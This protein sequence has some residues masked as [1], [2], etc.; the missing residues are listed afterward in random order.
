MAL[1]LH[2]AVR[3]AIPGINPDVQALYL[4][5]RGFAL[6]ATTGVSTPVYA[7]PY[8]VTVQV[9]PP[10]GR[11]LQ[12]INMLNLQGVVRTIYMYGN[13]QAINRV[14]AGGADL[15]MMP[16][17]QPHVTVD[18]RGGTV[19]DNLTNPILGAFPVDNWIVSAVDE[20]Y[21][22]E[23]LGW[24][25]LYVTLQTDGP[26]IVFDSNRLPVLDSNGSLVTSQ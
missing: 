4:A 26:Y 18:N 2:N 16:Q 17:W 5:S 25:K 23:G 10:S 3:S 11:D 24:T 9:Q 20:W 21:D 7:P 14:R 6:S 12:H 22:I 15:I 13:P 1:N 8:W 19:T